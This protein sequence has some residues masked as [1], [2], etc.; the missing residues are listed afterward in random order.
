MVRAPVVGE[1]GGLAVAVPA[2][3]A[4][5]LRGRGDGERRRLA[6]ERGVAAV[7]QEGEVLP[8]RLA[9]VEEGGGA[10]E[11]VVLLVER[12]GLRLH[13]DAAWPLGL[14]HGR[15]GEDL[16]VRRKYWHSCSRKM[17]GENS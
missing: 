3:V 1:H 10:V 11:G 16:R 13:G 12:V 15:R 7:G 4:A 9:V 6:A 17:M 5:A 2:A 14:R 8:L